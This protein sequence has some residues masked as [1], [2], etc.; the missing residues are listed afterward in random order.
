[1]ARRYNST[2]WE[3]KNAGPQCSGCN[4]EGQGKPTDMSIW[5]DK[6]YGAGTSEAMMFKANENFKLD[7]WF[8]ID[9]INKLKNK[10]GFNR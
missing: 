10:D 2:R 1:M 8:I 5:L 6:T 9:V 3:I 7:K 4:V